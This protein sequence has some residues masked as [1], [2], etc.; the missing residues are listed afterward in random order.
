MKNIKL[1]EWK[2]ICEIANGECD[3]CVLNMCCHFSKYTQKPRDWTPC[4]CKDCPAGKLYNCPCC[5]RDNERE[6]DL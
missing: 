5:E 1:S 4:D 3:N 2:E 6:N